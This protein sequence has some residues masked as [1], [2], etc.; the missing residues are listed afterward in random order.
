MLDDVTTTSD[1][2]GSGRG[3]LIGDG[4]GRI[5]AGSTVAAGRG[6][7]GKQ[8]AL[9]PSL[10]G[11]F[12]VATVAS[13]GAVFAASQHPDWRRMAGVMTAVH[14]GTAAAMIGVAQRGGTVVGRTLCAVGASNHAGLAWAHARLLLADRSQPRSINAAERDAVLR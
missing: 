3:V 4:V 5:I 14:V 11:A 1:S 6:W 8:I 12:G 9:P 2:E 10:V 7:I 13:G